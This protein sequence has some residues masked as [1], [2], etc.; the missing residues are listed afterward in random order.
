LSVDVQGLA[1]PPPGRLRGDL[2][3]VRGTPRRLAQHVRWR[4]TPWSGP[5]DKV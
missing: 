3:R 1:D 2:A 5:P 4:K